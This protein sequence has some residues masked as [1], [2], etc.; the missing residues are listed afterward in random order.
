MKRVVV[1]SSIVISAHFP[2]NPFVSYSQE[3][4]NLLEKLSQDKY[5][6][7]APSIFLYEC[8]NV[9]RTYFMKKFLEQEEVNELSGF[10]KQYNIKLIDFSKNC[11]RA[12]KIACAEKISIYDASYVALARQERCDFWTGDKKL[13][14]LLKT[15]LKFVKYVGNFK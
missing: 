10:I 9:L 14:Q 2:N 12:M 4:V 3:S 1:D 15:H 13:F 5:R 11:D 6:L 7:I 8:F